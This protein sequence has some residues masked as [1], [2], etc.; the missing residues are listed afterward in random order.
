MEELQK[1][2][3]TRVC[4]VGDRTLDTQPAIA[5]NTT[6]KLLDGGAAAA[7]AAAAEMRQQ[8]ASKTFCVS[9]PLHCTALQPQQRL[10]LHCSF[11]A[12][13]GCLCLRL[14]TCVMTRNERSM[15]LTCARS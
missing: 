3:G 8:A 14:L 7:A 12:S 4:Q 2:C 6:H 13:L 5:L 9:R 15:L 1:T 10:Q 11:C